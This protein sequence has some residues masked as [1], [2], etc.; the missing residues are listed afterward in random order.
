MKVMETYNNEDGQEFGIVAHHSNFKQVYI[1]KNNKEIC[2]YT[3]D[4]KE[5]ERVVFK[6]KDQS[7]I[8]CFI[9]KKSGDIVAN[10]S[11]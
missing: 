5:K 8:D 9:V 2:L 1:L 7:R 4:Q 6:S 10:V 11:S 3:L